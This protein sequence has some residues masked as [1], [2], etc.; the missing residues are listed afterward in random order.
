MITHFAEYE[1]PT[2]S[3]EG[4][5]QVYADRLGFDIVEHTGGYADEHT[6][7]RITFRVSA[8]TTLSF[9]EQFSPLHPAHFAFT[10]PWSKFEQAAEHVRESGLLIAR[11][12]GGSEVSPVGGDDSLSM[13]FRDGDGNIL[14]IIT[15]KHIPE[16]VLPATGPLHVAYLREVGFPTQ[17]AGRLRATLQSDLRMTSTYGGDEFDFVHS[18]TAFTITVS[19]SRPWVPIAMRALPPRQRVVF[20]TPRR[21][22]IAA[23]ADNVERSGRLL[24]RN[25]EELLFRY[26]EYILGLRHTPEVPAE[27]SE[28]ERKW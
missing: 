18:G 6:G 20:G 22:V 11:W 28:P 3:I 9:R 13:Y 2:V 19:T 10:V 21:D 17:D 8:L 14:E 5:K 4:V 26:D 15:Y 24:L 7:E 1:L 23:A 27:L 25:D 12:P 16:H